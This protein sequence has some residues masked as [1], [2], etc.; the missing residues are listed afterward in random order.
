MNEEQLKEKIRH[1][2][3]ELLQECKGRYLHNDNKHWHEPNGYYYY[4][5]AEELVDVANEL[6]KLNHIFELNVQHLN[7]TFGKEVEYVRDYNYEYERGGMEIKTSSLNEMQSLMNKASNQI[8]L[9]LYQILGD[10]NL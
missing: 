7:H 9:D 8:K 6:Y 2:Y 3:G 5:L 10:V 1:L 4:K